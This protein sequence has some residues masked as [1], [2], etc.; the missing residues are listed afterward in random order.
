M[1]PARCVEPDGDAIVGHGEWVQVL[2]GSAVGP[3][4][5]V[6]VPAKVPPPAGW[7]PGIEVPERK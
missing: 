1:P 2:T 7:L 5:W 3:V 6:V 4:V